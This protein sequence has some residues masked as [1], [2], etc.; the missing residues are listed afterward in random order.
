MVSSI[1]LQFQIRDENNQKDHTTL[2]NKLYELFS[3]CFE[4]F[5][6]FSGP[7]PIDADPELHSSFI[8]LF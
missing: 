6:L 1:P 2:F 4:Y 3:V 5:Y 8:S 7:H